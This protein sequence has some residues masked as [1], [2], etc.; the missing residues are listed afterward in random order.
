MSDD[1]LSNL[2]YRS[3]PQISKS[4]KRR[5]PFED[6]QTVLPPALSSYSIQFLNDGPPTSS[7]LPTQ[8]TGKYELDFPEQSKRDNTLRNKLAARFSNSSPEP[9]R[10]ITNSSE[11]K[12]T[13][14]TL[15]T[16]APR[17]LGRARRAN[18]QEELSSN[19]DT[20]QDSPMNEDN[21]V[22]TL[23]KFSPQENKLTKEEEQSIER[24]IEARQKKKKVELDLQKQ[25]NIENIFHSALQ[26]P[27]DDKKERVPL[28]N[29]PVN[30]VESFKK[31]KI[32][33]VYP[34]SEVN[35]NLQNKHQPP[36][37][38]SHTQPPPHAPTPPP[39]PPIM[40]PVV[41]DQNRYES[42][43]PHDSQAQYNI[44]R[45]SSSAVSSHSNNDMIQPSRNKRFI[46]INDRRYEKLELLGKGGSSKVY[47]IKDVNDHSIFALKKVAL[48]NY[49]DV[50]GFKGEIDLLKK[51]KTCS[52]VV[53][54][55]DHAITGGSIYLIME[56][57]DLDLA[58][59]FSHRMKLGASLDLNFVRYHAIEMF[60]CLKEVH[61]AGVVHSDLKPANF[62]FVKGMLKLIDF[63]IA[64]AVPEHTVNVYRESQIGTP[65][66]MAP[67]AI[68]DSVFSSSKNVWR[69]GKPSDIW[70]VGCILYQFIYGKAPFAAYTGHQKTLAITNPK[71]KILYP[72]YGIGNVPVPPSA[73][74]LMRNC[75]HRNPNDR[76]TNEQCLAS[77][78]L[79]PKI[80]SENFIRE[81]VH[82]TVNYGYN[83][84]LSGDGMTS[85]TYD[86]LVDSVLEQIEKLNY[87]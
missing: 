76:W 80:V 44:S 70:S 24:R 5:L 32:S 43:Y 35:P 23:E 33:K 58:D 28:R 26:S 46:I 82:K 62:L 78:F 13:A 56:K 74:E 71:I 31:P 59:V 40:H 22:P 1:I 6:D 86:A 48:D 19:I 50:N 15:G 53:R 18:E 83:S 69:V 47:R 68:G 36:G 8:V 51:L 3:S 72:E 2:R 21:I 85:D 75:L 64:N 9:S 61:D 81:V 29:L 25:I 52:R 39:P 41:Q 67:E 60:K 20:L 57:G 11:N 84:R 54:L 34:V 73:I 66:Y 17:N 37:H 14:N 63:G 45:S 7:T 55:V 49:E 16:T 79:S 10:S 38:Y 12:L 4:V 65:N 42:S 30:K 27:F 77:D 87:S